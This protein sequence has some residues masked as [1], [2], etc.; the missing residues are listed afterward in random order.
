MAGICLIEVEE[1]I[2]Y[3]DLWRYDSTNYPMGKLMEA[4]AFWKAGDACY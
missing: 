1:L 3:I 4:T 2:G